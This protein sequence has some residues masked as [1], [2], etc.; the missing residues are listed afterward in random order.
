MKTTTEIQCR[1]AAGIESR[2]EKAGNQPEATIASSSEMVAR[3]VWGESSSRV[4]MSRN[5]F[6]TL[7]PSP[8]SKRGSTETPQAPGVEVLPDLRSGQMDARVPWELVRSVSLPLRRARKRAKL[9]KERPGALEA[10]RVR[11][12][13][14]S[15]AEEG[16]VTRKQ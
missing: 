13:R 16:I 4:I 14:K 15:E 8:S 9:A 12:E 5:R 1:N 10:T 2:P 6:L 7:E 3:N 11:C